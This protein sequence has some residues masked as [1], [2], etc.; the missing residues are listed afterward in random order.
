MDSNKES[1]DHF[2]TSPK[3]YSNKKKSKIVLEIRISTNEFH[4]LDVTVFFNIKNYEQHYLIQQ[5]FIFTYLKGI[6]F[7][8]Y[9]FSQMFGEF[10]QNLENFVPKK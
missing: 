2:F 8:G 10:D 3:N 4:F 6:N 5:R 9:K 7:C 1:F